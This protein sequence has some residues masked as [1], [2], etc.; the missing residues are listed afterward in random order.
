VN[1]QGL[2]YHADIMAG[3]P[4]RAIQLLIGQST[5]TEGLF[6]DIVYAG[7]RT[8][9]PVG[10]CQSLRCTNGVASDRAGAIAAKSFICSS[11]GT[12]DF[13]TP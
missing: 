13:S 11:V 9:S 5:L 10:N 12:D 4:S 7:S 1:Q 8:S 3:N 2:D 6:E